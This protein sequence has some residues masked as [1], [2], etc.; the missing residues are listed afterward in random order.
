MKLAGA[1]VNQ[2][3]GQCSLAVERIFYIVPLDVGN[4]EI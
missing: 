4:V 2:D 1:T 3:A